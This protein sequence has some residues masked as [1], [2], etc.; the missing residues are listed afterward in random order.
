MPSCFGT[1]GFVRTRREHPVRVLGA[2]RPDLLAVDQ[3]VVAAV[4]GAGAQAGEVGPGARFAVA[5]TPA[6]VRRAR[7]AG[8]AGASGLRCRVRAASG[9]SSTCPCPSAERARRCA[10]S[11]R[12]ARRTVLW[13][14]RRRRTP[15]A[16]SARSSRF[17]AMRVSHRLRVGIFDLDLRAAGRNLAGSAR[18]GWTVLRQP[19]PCFCTKIVDRRHH[20]LSP[21]EETKD[22]GTAHNI[23]EHGII[24][25]L[26]PHHAIQTSMTDLCKTADSYPAE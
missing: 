9:R 17:S 8:C 19:G 26:Q 3:E 24:A 12:S 20:S 15:S 5:L 1:S 18:A 4:F 13:S 2:R 7:S 22:R 16:T 25:T 14:D 6:R 10:A 11:L 21:H 23:Q